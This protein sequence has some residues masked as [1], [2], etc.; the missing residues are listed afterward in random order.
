MHVLAQC[1][2]DEAA[3]VLHVV[4]VVFK[5]LRVNGNAGHHI[6]DLLDQ[7]FQILAAVHILHQHLQVAVHHLVVLF[8]QRLQQRFAQM[9]ITDHSLSLHVQQGA[10]DFE[11][12]E[13]LVAVLLGENSAHDFDQR[14]RVHFFALYL[15]LLLH[16]FF[17]LLHS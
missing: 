14:G 7:R 13:A 16:S 10:D 1:A 9:L 5:H 3:A 15:Q 12:N 6:H 4:L 8:L 2:D 17:S 11:A